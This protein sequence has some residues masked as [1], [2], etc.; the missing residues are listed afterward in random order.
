M[1]PIKETVALLV[2]R[3]KKQQKAAL[4]EN[5]EACLKKTLTKKEFGHIKC[6]Y[7]KKG[8]LSINVDSSAWLYY[9]NL[10][11]EKLLAA[12]VKES[13]LVKDIRLRLGEVR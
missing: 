7:F 5:P 11:K 4:K 6:N 12:L 2:V 1:E 9:F 3:L 10:R 13:S 8:T